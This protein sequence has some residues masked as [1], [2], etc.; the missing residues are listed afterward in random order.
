MQSSQKLQL[1]SLLSMILLGAASA[2]P[3]AVLSTTMLAYLKEGNA[4]LAF[5]GALAFW[6]FPYSIKFLWAPLLD[7][8]PLPLRNLGRRKGWMALIL[9]GLATFLAYLPTQIA[10][11]ENVGWMCFVFIIA[12]LGASFD[13]VADAYRRDAFS[14]TEYG[15]ATA[16]F[17]I[18]YRFGSLFAGGIALGIAEYYSWHVVFMTIG[19]VA[20]LGLWGI[21]LGPRERE[22]TEEHKMRTL[23]ESFIQPLKEL[24]TIKNIQLVVG[25][26]LFYKLGDSLIEALLTPFLLEIGYKKIDIA[27]AAKTFGLAAGLLGGVVGAVVLEKFSIQRSLMM[28]GIF[29]LFAN[30]GFI[31]LANTEPSVTALA[32]VNIF[33]KLAAGISG[34]VLA[35]FLGSLCSV[36]FSATQYAIFTSL[37]GIPRDIASASAGYFVERIGWSRFF[38]M[39]M[40]LA[41]IALFILRMKEFKKLIEEKT[42]QQQ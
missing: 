10:L 6:K 17:I 19:V 21:I 28:A 34:T 3:I 7:R 41:T 5:M 40:L 20:L 4:G 31:Y 35:A 22:V 15:K 11:T 38:V 2:I 9:V 29:Q 14:L 33:E 42:N 1:K 25:F 8:Y 26:L 12:F 16:T 13:I 24:L 39:S 23:A 32:V 18:G 27:Y 30:A 37:L 36:Q